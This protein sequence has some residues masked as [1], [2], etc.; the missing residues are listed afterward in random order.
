[1]DRLGESH[2]A[3][4]QRRAQDKYDGKVESL[5]ALKE[6]RECADYLAGVLENA[7]F[8]AEDAEDMVRVALSMRGKSAGVLP[9]TPEANQYSFDG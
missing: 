4:Q 3:Y 6:F 1:M 9:T 5:V 7:V 2:E 8:D